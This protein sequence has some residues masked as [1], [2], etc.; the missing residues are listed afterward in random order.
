MGFFC[1]FCNVDFEVLFVE[2]NAMAVLNDM[3][4]LWLIFLVLNIISHLLIEF[5]EYSL[6]KVWT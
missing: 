3:V 4:K 1:Y 6:M 5:V 2:S